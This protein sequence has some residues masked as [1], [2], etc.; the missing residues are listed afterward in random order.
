MTSLGQYAIG[1]VIECQKIIAKEADIP[2]TGGGSDLDISSITLD[3]KWKI[4]L[5]TNSN[6]ILENEVYNVISLSGNAHSGKITLFDFNLN[7]LANVNTNNVQNGSV[8]YYD[9][10]TSTYEFTDTL[11]FL[12]ANQEW[13][14]QNVPLTFT[15]GDLKILQDAVDLN[16]NIY[17]GGIQRDNAPTDGNSICIG[18]LSGGQQQKKKCIAI[19]YG[20]GS[21][22]QGNSP[23]FPQF[24]GGSIA[25]GETCGVNQEHDCLA[26]GTDAGQINQK[27]NS[28]CFGTQSGFRNLNINSLAIGHNAGQLDLCFGSIAIGF[29]SAKDN[30]DEY[31]VH[32][33][34]FAGENNSEAYTVGIG[35]KANNLQ[36]KLN[37]IAIGKE[38]GERFLK[39]NSIAIGTSSGKN[40]SG[41]NCIYIGES[42]GLDGGDFS[43]VIVLN[44][45]STELNPSDNSKCYI[46]PIAS[47]TS[48]NILQYNSLTKEITYQ[49]T[50]SNIDITNS[51]TLNQQTGNA[52]QVLTSQAASAPIWTT[53]TIP[54]SI[55][56]SNID[57]TNSLTL[58]QQTGVS[59]EVLTSQGTSAPI[60]IA[61]SSGSS[62]LA[63]S[64]FLS[65][66]FAPPTGNFSINSA[67]QILTFASYTEA[68]TSPNV[69][70]NTGLGT[71]NINIAGTYIINVMVTIRALIASSPAASRIDARLR[72]NQTNIGFSKIQ[73]LSRNLQEAV[74]SINVIAT[75]A[76]NDTID[77]QGAVSE[78]TFTSS[79]SWNSMESKIYFLKIA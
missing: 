72:N 4:Y 29:N 62:S 76:A 49:N 66:G 34:S 18:A 51:L 64:S 60:W 55:T 63:V 68:I 58:N 2:S 59:G 45:S 35:Y 26:I 78:V 53:P 40:N 24:E 9:N 61:P 52:G 16:K 10:L 65:V 5:D 48:G 20:A 44:A 32:I 25:I 43:N 17:I 37:S 69:S 31:A 41:E 33:G 21:N 39:K 54:T 13:N 19:G 1:G 12:K 67:A 50:V 70:E 57:I 30:C 71:F 8:M 28:L 75:L 22:G 56:V 77:L 11:R 47:A 73:F 15:G 38:A 27:S 7:D 6:F 74:I 79:A 42:A 3:S 23:I 36:A 14:I 46:N